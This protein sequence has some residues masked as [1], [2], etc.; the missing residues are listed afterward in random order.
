MTSVDGDMRRIV[1]AL[2][3][4]NASL[5]TL[6]GGIP[7]YAAALAEFAA[8]VQPV[9]INHSSELNETF[10]NLT[11]AQDSL[12]NSTLRIAELVDMFK[13]SQKQYTEMEKRLA[14]YTARV[15]AGELE[16]VDF[17]FEY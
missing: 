3:A 11:F 6:T 2:N 13:E 8:R 5:I 15:D 7:G 17:K 16:R 14:E 10:Y 9:Y 1:T 4:S 12:V